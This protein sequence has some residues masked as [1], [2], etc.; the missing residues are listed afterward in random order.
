MEKRSAIIKA[1]KKPDS[2]NLLVVFD[3]N[4]QWRRAQNEDH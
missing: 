2:P 3:K 1:A 4:I